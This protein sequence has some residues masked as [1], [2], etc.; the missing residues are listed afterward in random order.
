ML[1][2]GAT[3]FWTM[4]ATTL[5]SDETLELR[6]KLESYTIGICLDAGCHAKFQHNEILKDVPI[7][8][9]DCHFSQACL[10]GHDNRRF[11]CC[12]FCDSQTPYELV[13]PV[14]Q[15]ILNHFQANHPQKLQ[16]MQTDMASRKRKLAK[17][18]D[19]IEQSKKDAVK[20][21]ASNVKLK[22][23]CEKLRASLLEKN[24]A[25]A[26]HEQ[27]IEYC[28]EIGAKIRNGRDEILKKTRE[29]N[30]GTFNS[31]SLTNYSNQSYIQQMMATPPTPSVTG[32]D[33]STNASVEHNLECLI[34]LLY[35]VMRK[36]QSS[37]SSSSSSASFVDNQT[38]M[39]DIDQFIEL[40]LAL[41]L[42]TVLHSGDR[43]SSFP[44]GT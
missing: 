43:R 22:I 4:N 35:E 44:L 30:Q 39:K 19:E 27:L 36:P 37:S 9:T 11:L 23:A 28:K 25:T 41:I 34:V 31:E 5:M 15:A 29:L 16:E 26:S 1:V 14:D 12:L 13:L 10:E 3:F 21:D 40:G 42:G 20:L 32:T 6:E 18:N 24:I 8:I 38:M 7:V 33:I 2:L 17:E